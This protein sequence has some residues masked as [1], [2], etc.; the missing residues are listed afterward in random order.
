MSSL[1]LRQSEDINSKTLFNNEDDA[2]LV[3]AVEMYELQQKDKENIT[4]P[5]DKDL[6]NQLK[7]N[8]N[9][10]QPLE[11]NQHFYEEIDISNT[12]HN[13]Y[14]SKELEKGY[15][16]T[17]Y[18]DM[19]QFDIRNYKTA[20]KNYKKNF[21]L[22]STDR[23]MNMGQVDEGNIHGIKTVHPDI[24][25]QQTVNVKL[26]IDCIPAKGKYRNESLGMKNPR[27]FEQCSVQGE[28]DKKV[29]NYPEIPRSNEKVWNYPEI[30][31]SNEK[32]WNCPEI[33]NIDE[34]VCNY[35]KI[36]EGKKSKLKLD[37][38]ELASDYQ[39]K[40]ASETQV[41]NHHKIPSTAV[42]S[43]HNSPEI[44]IAFADKNT[45]ENF[46][47]MFGSNEEELSIKDIFNERKCD[48]GQF[49]LAS[50]EEQIKSV[51]ENWPKE[52]HWNDRLKS[53]LEYKE[54]NKDKEIETVDFINWSEEKDKEE[55]LYLESRYR[56]LNWWLY[57]NNE[58]KKN[59]EEN[60]R[61][62]ETLQKHDSKH[63]KYQKSFIKLENKNK[64][65][66][67]CK[68]IKHPNYIKIK[69]LV[70]LGNKVRWWK[71]LI[72]NKDKLGNTCSTELPENQ[73]QY[74]WKEL[75]MVIEQTLTIVKSNE[76]HLEKIQK[77]MLEEDNKLLKILKSLKHV[78]SKLELIETN[79]LISAENNFKKTMEN[80]KLGKLRKPTKHEMDKERNEQEDIS[81]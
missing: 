7:I 50:M 47:R 77:K 38:E 22:N 5:K 49:E 19:N 27:L 6:M 25:R 75:Q 17:L 52:N 48:K 33:P 63:R 12:V 72:Q 74:K 59:S 16:E 57:G 60:P 4:E 46:K 43:N 81:L 26:P 39:E 3:Q 55:G 69:E 78:E 31:R 41:W 37:H 54:E 62:K 29:W 23:I 32:V 30:P 70:Q 1:K 8:D 80:I 10:I 66:T 67:N 64:K 45:S 21:T 28:E 76:N 79:L 36:P 11:N 14:P 53:Y 58:P 13:L 42:G 73:C 56:F 15:E 51:C 34:M 2:I 71:Q 35:S 44:P 20:D 9:H 68:K 61:L 18:E 24:Q 65:I 40:F